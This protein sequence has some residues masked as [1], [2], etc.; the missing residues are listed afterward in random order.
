MSDDA[1]TTLE[2]VKAGFLP[3]TAAGANTW[4]PRLRIGN[5]AAVA[6]VAVWLFPVYWI[7]LTSFKPIREINSAVPSF[8]F[9]PT[10][11]NYGDLF[12]QFGFV[13]VLVNSLVV[14]GATCAIV[15]VFGVLAAYALGRMQVPGEKHIAL[16][17]LSLRFLPPIAV[18]IPF[19]IQ[20]QDLGLL[21]T[22]LGLVLVYVAFNLP[23]AIWLLRGFLADVP[24]ELEE[25]AL[26]DGLSRL[27]VIWR[28]VV[29][30]IL[31]GIAATAIFTFVFAWNEYLMALM[32]TSVHAVTVPVTIAK[33]VMPYTILWGDLSAAVVIQVV[34]M[35]AV[36]FVLQRHIVRGM[37]LGAVK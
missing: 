6:V 14:T 7:V 11:E 4:R 12:T 5:L 17:I 19:Y 22:Y 31:P 8:I 27:Q 1:M 15:M 16:W 29:P 26:L 9:T 36:V 2:Q 3:R 30:V 25:A 24:N 35:L 18:T 33:F 37:T 32:L 13:R 20:W 23:F 28:V 34:P 21:D 10:I